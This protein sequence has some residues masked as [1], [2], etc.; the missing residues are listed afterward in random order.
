MRFKGLDLNLLVALD[1]LLTE[2][3]VSVAARRI[4]LSQS[5]MS[6]ALA[7]LRDHFQDEL[8]V[9]LG[10]RLVLT[11]FAESIVE[12][13]HQLMLQ[14]EATVDTGNAF[15]PTT[16]RRTFK[17]AVS[18]Y[19]TE[20]L[21]PQVAAMVAKA[22]PAVMLDIIAPDG[23]APEMI[24][25]G[26]IDI[27]IVSEH[28]LS[29]LHP[30]EFL[31]EESHVI[32]GCRTNR[33]LQEPISTEDFFDIGRVVGRFGKRR[34][35]S[36]GEMQLHRFPYKQ[37]IE[38]VTPS[39]IAIPKFLIETERV[40]LVNKALANFYTSTLPLTSAPLP[41]YLKP[42]QIVLQH[43]T[44]RMSDSGVQWLKSVI[45]EAVAAPDYWYNRAN[46]P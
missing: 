21:L 16:S 10:R 15:D 2:M 17:L 30:F 24:E 37:K 3:N 29:P 6:G 22:A 36:F 19:M 46:R 4:F 34:A 12:P 42:L 38:L 39:F 28:A 26:S 20:L 32:I 5:A 9:P 13:V 40:A 18:D 45:R 43:H 33:I 31:A 8:L 27:S 44:V 35:L 1:A 23:M 41:F 11:A 14:I 7:R 25:N